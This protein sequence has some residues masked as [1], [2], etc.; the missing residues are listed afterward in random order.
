MYSKEATVPL[1]AGLTF[2]WAT[3]PSG[4]SPR[5]SA[6]FLQELV[7]A[8]AGE[9]QV[10]GSP[11]LAS[12]SAGQA[13]G[14]ASSRRLRPFAAEGDSSDAVPAAA[15]LAAAGIETVSVALGLRG[16][17]IMKLQP[18]NRQLRK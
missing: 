16:G 14:E 6:G 8:L 9:E 15:A 7:E 11:A 10:P 3:W 2:R 5:A 1:L 12:G 4:A 13:A 17:A 18:D